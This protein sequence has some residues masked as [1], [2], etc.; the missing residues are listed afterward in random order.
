MPTKFTGLQEASIKSQM[1]ICI[2]GSLGIIGR[3]YKNI[4]ELGQKLD[5]LQASN[6]KSS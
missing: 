2:S 1:S 3:Y 6:G 5:A 4:D